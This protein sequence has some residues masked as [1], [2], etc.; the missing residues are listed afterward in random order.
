MLKSMTKVRSV[1]AL[2]LVTWFGVA[3]PS[4]SSDSSSNES[5]TCTLS[6]NRCEFDCSQNL[7]C[8]E[9]VQN[10]DCATVTG[11]PL[12]VLGSCRACAE[13]ANCATGQVCAPADHVCEAPCTT[14]A[15][16]TD[17]NA[18][19]C[20]TTNAPLGVCV[21]CLTAANCPTDAP[22][23]DATRKQCSECSGNANCG[24]AKPACNLQ[25]GQCE[26]CLVDSDCKAANYACGSDHT[27]HALCTS[28][29][30]CASN[31][32]NFVGNGPLCN[33]DTGAC[34]ECLLGTDCTDPLQPVCGENFTCTACTLGGT[35]CPAA[36][37]T[38]VTYQGVGQGN[39]NQTH[40][41]ACQTNAE[42]T[43]TALPTC[44]TTT[45][46]CVAC[47]TNAECTNAALPTCSDAG[48]CVA[49]GG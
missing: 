14:D 18:P 30:D 23:C 13:S 28:N 48:V 8:V 43:N 32:N 36:T 17:P 6:G 44:N 9:C 45:G 24:V 25:N 47:Q 19:L 39:R 41:V 21:G 22:I 35:D 10:A 31:Q 12:C 26:V 2:A 29:T 11:A 42:C 27:C 16:C 33:L 49:A 38:C 3:V 40:C 37:P 7:G 4:C 15:N 46:L 1:T 20:D 34:V 5:N